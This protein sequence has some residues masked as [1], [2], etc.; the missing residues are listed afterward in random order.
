M[1]KIFR[2]VV[3]GSI[4]TLLGAVVLGC[5][6]LFCYVTA[7]VVSMGWYRAVEQYMATVIGLQ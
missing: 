2:F 7:F 6:L 4:L 1:K 3:G 5:W